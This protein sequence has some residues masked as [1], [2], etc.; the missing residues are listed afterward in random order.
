MGSKSKIALEIIAFLPKG[1]RLVDLFGG[2]MAI[3]ECGM[4]SKKWDKYLYNELNPLVVDLVK[5]AINGDFDCNKFKPVFIT[6]EEFEKKKNKDGYIK[7]IWSFSNQGKSYMFG[8]NVYK[9]KEQGHN[10]CIF[11]KPIEGLNIPIIKGTPYQKRMFLKKWCQATFEKEWKRATPRIKS[12]YKK[13]QDIMDGTS[14]ASKKLALKFTTWLKT[15]GIT[16]KEIKELTNSDMASHYLTTGS[17]PAIP[18]DEMWKL[19]KKSP[20][21]KNIPH[22]IELICNS[23]EKIKQLQ[24]LQQLERLQRLEITNKSYLDYEYQE[25]DVVYCDP[26]YENTADYN[27]SSF[28]HKEFYDW[29]ASRP[30]PVYFSSYKIS[31]DRFKVVWACKKR[32]LMNGAR[33]TAHNYECI[34]T[35]K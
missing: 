26:P 29:V 7:Y 30:Y 10:Y 15:T 24:Q 17:Q 34:Y 11:D 4:Y 21:L 5:R 25:G 16:A 6:S 3:T 27:E 13:Y 18:T 19:M 35:Q 22:E 31:D 12:D 8:K 20:K 28:N 1:K 23:E 14:K 33:T 9:I 2:G 32:S